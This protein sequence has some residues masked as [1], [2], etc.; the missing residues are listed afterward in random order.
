MLP[1]C[2]TQIAA[3]SEI[4]FLTSL[5]ISSFDKP[6]AWGTWTLTVYLAVVDTGKTLTV[7]ISAAVTFAQVVL[8]ALKFR[9]AFVK[10]F[11][12]ASI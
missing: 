10:S 7:C 4:I 6:F 5:S 11:N 8:S 9:M 2:S 1:L 3:A 12:R